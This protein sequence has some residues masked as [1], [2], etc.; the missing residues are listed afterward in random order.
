MNVL[1]DYDPEKNLFFY[2]NK[3]KTITLIEKSDEHETELDSIVLGK[4]LNL[5]DYNKK[6]WA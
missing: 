3:T 2:D 1:A 4:L 6:F 5:L